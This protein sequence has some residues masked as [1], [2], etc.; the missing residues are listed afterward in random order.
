MTTSVR[1]AT[2][3]DLDGIAAIYAHEVRTSVATFEF[4]APPRSRWEDKL[5]SHEVS[6]HRLVAVEGDHVLGY[7][8]SGAYRPRHGYRHTRE[9]SVYVAPGAHGQGLGRRLYDELVDLLRADGVHLALAGVALPN[10]TSVRLHEA[11]GF[12]LVGTMREVG[13]KFDRWIDTAWYQLHL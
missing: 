7:T 13:H 12:E 11:V 4:E 2:D 8:Y 10:D 3:A 9:V 1:P 5:A 6:D